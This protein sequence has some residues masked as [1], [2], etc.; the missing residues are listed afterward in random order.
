MLRQSRKLDHI[1]HAINLRNISESESLFDDVR[2]LHDCLPELNFDDISLTDKLFGKDINAPIMINALTG[3][4]VDVAVYNEKLAFL[5]KELQI[6]IAVGSQYAALENTSVAYTFEIVRNINPDGIV[7]ANLG[8]H[9]TVNEA[10]AAVN[11]ISADA[12]QIHINPAQELIMSEGDRNF[13]GYLENIKCIKE[14]INVPIIVKETGCGISSDSLE[15]ILALGIS[16]V[17][18]SG[19][20]GTNFLEIENMRKNDVLQK[21]LIKWGIP[22]VV[23]IISASLKLKN[24][25]LLVASGGIT[26]P[27]HVAKSLALGADIAGMSMYFLD[28]VTR[29]PDLTEAIKEFEKFTKELKVIMLLTGSESV[30][31]LRSKRVHLSLSLCNWLDT[32]DI[33]YKDIVRQRR[34]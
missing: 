12:L 9:A 23:S 13:R 27:M 33:N 18:V 20:G 25:D 7:I 26:T 30:H 21:D 4:S 32:Y 2:L 28:L 16:N 24:K 31:N 15:K 8:A 3:G 1:V 6:P 11:M 5:A 19:L 17:D 14:F 10:Q 34:C 29:Y 22:T